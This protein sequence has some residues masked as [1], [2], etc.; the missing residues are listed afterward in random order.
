[1]NRGGIVSTYAHFE[2]SEGNFKIRLFDKEAPST[3]ANFVGLAEGSK[4]WRDPATLGGARARS[5]T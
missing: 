4:E 2:T 3:V 5:D 1:M